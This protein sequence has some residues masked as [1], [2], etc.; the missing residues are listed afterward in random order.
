VI[1]ALDAEGRWITRGRFAKESKGLEFADRIET[2]T[3]I[4]NL[5]LLTDYIQ[6]GR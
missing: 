4:A 5:D 2:A 3:F 6:A 1:A